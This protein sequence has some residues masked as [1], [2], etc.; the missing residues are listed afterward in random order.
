[1]KTSQ[2]NLHCV[3]LLLFALFAAPVSNSF[4]ANILLTG[5][6]V[7]PLPGDLAVAEYLFDLGHSVDYRVGADVRG[8]DIVAG[9]FD[10]YIMSSTSL[11]STIRDNGLE[12][13]PTP[14]LTWESS[15]VRDVPGEFYITDD[16]QSG[17]LGVSI[18]VQD[19]AHPIM[20]GIDA[21]NGDDI[22]IFTEPQNFFGLIGEFAEGANLIATGTEDE[23][24]E[25]RIM[26][27]ELPAG[28]EVLR[29]ETSSFLGGLSPGLRVHIPLSDTSFPFLND[30]GLQIF[31]N[32]VNYALGELV[33]IS[34]GDFNEDGLLTIPDIDL[35]MDEI[36]RGGE[37]A[38]FDLNGDGR[39]NDA[40]RDEWLSIAGT[41]NGL[42][43]PYLVGDSNLDTMVNVNDLNALAVNWLSPQNAWS[44]GN[45]TGDEVNST[46]LNELALNWQRSVPMASATNSTVPEPSTCVLMIIGLVYYLRERYY[47]MIQEQKSN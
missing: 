18:I 32:A 7:L 38:T 27:I 23:G 9:G 17:D 39:V 41:A 35:L 37:G 16:Q 46:D 36:G 24:L 44:D 25:E 28:A 31:T 8:E 21:N 5:A 45:F 33:P 47:R 40:D 34:I 4:A 42:S 6:E 22:E 26:I 13:I 20:T 43:G 12:Q 14:I 10:L 3:R 29:P 2:F 19:A 1:M 11:T 30:T 15:M